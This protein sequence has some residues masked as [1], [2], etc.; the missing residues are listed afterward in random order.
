M[1]H[2]IIQADYQ[3][4]T[5]IAHRMRT[6]ANNVRKVHLHLLRA[7]SHLRDSWVGRGAVA[8]LHE[9]DNDLLPA[10]RRLVGALDEA[11]DVTEQIVEIIRHAEERAAALFVGGQSSAPPK[12]LYSPFAPP[13][14]VTNPY[15]YGTLEWAQYGMLVEAGIDPDSYDPTLGFD[16]N[17]QMIVRCLS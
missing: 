4:L 8:F 11:A 9:M 16:H 6:E 5:L 17:R 12:G 2:P 3:R 7:C 14:D 10:V 1:H 13:W 15:P